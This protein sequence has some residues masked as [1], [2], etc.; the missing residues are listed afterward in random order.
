MATRGDDSFPPLQRLLRDA[1]DEP[2]DAGGVRARA[3]QLLRNMDDL[4]IPHGQKQRLLFRLGQGHAS[5]A[6]RFG[7]LRPIVIGAF[8]MGIG[9]G[10]VASAGMTK[11]PV[12][13]VW[14]VRSYRKLVSGSADPSLPAAAAAPAGLGGPGPLGGGFSGRRAA[15]GHYR[16]A[17]PDR[18]DRRDLAVGDR[19][20]AERAARPPR[21]AAA[22]DP[23]L[24]R[25]DDLERAGAPLGRSLGAAG[26]KL[27]FVFSRKRRNDTGVND[28]AQAAR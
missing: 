7:W 2:A 19:A 6:R 20:R 12:W 5:R 8:L 15:A 4:Q 28:G 22:H 1:T 17:L 13:P 9:G 14:I 3:V 27:P 26:R 23:G 11:W 18:P 21:C 10:A 16:A 24:Y 25:A